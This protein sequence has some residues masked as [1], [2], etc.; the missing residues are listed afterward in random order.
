MKEIVLVKSVYWLEKEMEV[1]N[2]IVP[3]RVQG[4]FDNQT[5]RYQVAN[6]ITTK[7]FSNN[8]DQQAA[9][10]LTILDMQKQMVMKMRE[11]RIKWDSENGNSGLFADDADGGT[12]DEGYNET[13]SD[14]M[15]LD[16]GNAWGNP[17][18]EG[19]ASPATGKKKRP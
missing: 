3:F 2:E 13:G 9:I 17:L 10:E 16:Q 8:P 6:R 19:E 12:D 7:Q 4:T 15:N 18:N 14:E 11:L 5:G 1:Q